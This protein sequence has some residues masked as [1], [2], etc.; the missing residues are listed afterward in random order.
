MVRN[1]NGNGKDAEEEYKVWR[2]RQMTGFSGYG[3]RKRDGRW[4]E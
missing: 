4:A 1:G 3:G 2:P